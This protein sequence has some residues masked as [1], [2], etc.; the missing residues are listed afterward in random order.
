MTRIC[1]R[2]ASRSVSVNSAGVCRRLAKH[3]T[4]ARPHPLMIN[5]TVSHSLSSASSNIYSDGF[6]LSSFNY[7][8]D[9]HI[10][11]LVA[12]REKYDRFL[13]SM[14]HVILFY[15]TYMHK[16]LYRQYSSEPVSYTSKPMLSLLSSTSLPYSS[17]SLKNHTSKSSFL[18]TLLLHSLPRSAISTAILFPTSSA[19]K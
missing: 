5:A 14:F 15:D 11:V 10:L 6:E 3:A 8:L 17:K 9:M 7:L 19:P 13:P 12:F 2:L 4:L 1:C 16:L 18:S